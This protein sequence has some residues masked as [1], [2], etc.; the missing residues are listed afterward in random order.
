M[1]LDVVETAGR[2]AGERTSFEY[3]DTSWRPKS[4]LSVGRRFRVDDDRGGSARRPVEREQVVA[5]QPIDDVVVTGDEGRHEHD[6]REEQDDPAELHAFKA[7][8][9]SDGHKEVP[10][11]VH[12]WHGGEV[13]HTRDAVIGRSQALPQG[14]DKA[15]ADHKATLGHLLLTAANIARDTGFADDGYRVVINTNADGGQ[16]VFHLHVHLLAGRPFIFPPG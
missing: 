4:E 3:E 15:E 9:E 13:V 2:N 5:E 8:E 6:N 1:L 10:P 12:A 7:H 11:N 14:V 16:T